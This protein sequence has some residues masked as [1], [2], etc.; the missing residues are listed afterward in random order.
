[1]L[2]KNSTEPQAAPVRDAKPRKAKSRAAVMSAR[3]RIEAASGGTSTGNDQSG[4]DNKPPGV[5]NPE[6]YV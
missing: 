2:N 6:R 1:M 4:T 3:S 5:C